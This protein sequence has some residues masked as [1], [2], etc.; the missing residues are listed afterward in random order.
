MQQ[1]AE[2]VVQYEHSPNELM[3]HGHNCMPMQSLLIIICV[4]AAEY[5]I[6]CTS[7]TVDGV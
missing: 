4:H 7:V 3:S 6:T 2:I 5:S 1:D